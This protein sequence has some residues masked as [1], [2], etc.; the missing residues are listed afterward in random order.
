MED[1]CD[2][3]S[4]SGRTLA[5]PK[6]HVKSS[7]EK[8]HLVTEE[9]HEVARKRV[10]MRDLE[11][12]L[13]REGTNNH[14]PK[15]VKD[16]GGKVSSQCGEEG[17]GRSQVTE[18]PVTSITNGSHDDKSERNSLPVEGNCK[19]VQL[20]LNTEICSANKFESDVNPKHTG[21]TKEADEVSL[22]RQHETSSD[23]HAYSKGLDLNLNAEDLSSSVNVNP[24]YPYKN[25][26]QLK[27][28]DASECASSTGPLE[29]K[30]SFRLWNEMKQNGF[31]SSAH[32]GIPIPKQRGR[33]SKNDV[34]KKKLE[35]AKKEQ[36]DRFTKIAAPSGLLNELNPGIINHVRNRKQVHSIIEALVRSGRAENG[37]VGSKQ[38]GHS[39][40]ET[41]EIGNGKALG[42]FDNSG[43]H[44]LSYSSENVAPSSL[45]ER[46]QTT[47]FP[48]SM[49]NK[50]S[51]SIS[52]HEVENGDLGMAGGLC[53]KNLVSNPN[54]ISQDDGLALRLS[55]ITSKASEITWSMSNEDSTTFGSVTSLS[56]KAATV[57]SQWL[58]L[59]HQDIKG[60]LAALKRSKKRVQAVINTE[61]PF[62]ISKEFSSNQENN[63]HLTNSPI[64]DM[65]LSKWS[66]LFCQMDK[67]LSEEEQQLEIWLNQVKEMQ[68]HCEHG[69]Q[70]VQ[71]NV[72]YSSENLGATDIISRSNKPDNSERELA[73]R[74]AAASIYSTCNFLLAKENVSCC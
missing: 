2:S 58:E 41:K 1:Q 35:L 7:G 40:G 14:S 15:S 23:H 4:V 47:G 12:V 11:S 63:P 10:K 13:R 54:S 34:L 25:L 24:F 31:L 37:H 72:P 46:K 33:K 19:P 42:C 28:V 64:A 45:C 67:A 52:E 70:H 26:D 60:R 27:P 32:G 56:V 51:S 18:E 66:A 5:S 9:K 17:L 22:F 62:L 53:K 43:K 74:A 49:L 36:V 20:D 6:S 38:A 39:K 65:H 48:M 59:L 44:Q 71:W 68:S 21:E 8:R 61:L 30:D 29:E 50:Y 3:G 55:S 57:A 16:K 73:V 69:L